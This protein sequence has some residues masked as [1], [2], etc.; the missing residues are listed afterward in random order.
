MTIDRNDPR[1]TAYVLGELEEQE[2]AEFEKEIESA[3]DAEAILAETRDAVTLLHEGFASEQPVYLSA[4]QKRAIEVRGAPSI[5]WLRSR[6]R[7]TAGLA[8]A[9]VVLMGV[10][11]IMTPGLLRSRQGADAKPVA[12]NVEVESAGTSPVTGSPASG[13]DAGDG[14]EPVY[15][16]LERQ[17]QASE[18][19][20]SAPQAAQNIEAVRTIESDS[21]DVPLPSVSRES[22]VESAQAPRQ[23]TAGIEGQVTDLT[24]AA[25]AGVEVAVTSEATGQLRTG[26]TDQSGTYNFQI[27]RA[28]SYRV[29]TSRP[30]FETSTRS[31]VQVE[32]QRNARVD[33]ALQVGRARRS[34]T[35]MGVLSGVLGGA[36]STSSSPAPPLGPPVAMSVVPRF[37]ASGDPIDQAQFNTE[38]YDRI[39]DNPFVAVRE[40]PLATFSI[41]VDTAAYANVRRFLNQRAL[42][43][44]NAV[45]I[46]EMVNYFT[47]GYAGPTDEHPVRVHAEV[48]AAPWNPEHRLVRLGVQGRDVPLE[49]RGPSNLV[50]LIDV[51]GS[52]GGV[53]K[54]PLLRDGMKLLVGQ[55]DEN[56]RVAIVVYADASGMVLPSTPGDQKQRLLRALD[57]LEAGGSTNGAAGIELAYDTATAHFIDGGTNRVILATDGDFNVGVT[58]SGALTLLIEEKAES[59]V[60]LSVLGFGTGNYNDAGL[61]ALADHGN[62]NYAYIDTIRE[63]RKV[64]V[65]QM[66]ST[67]ITIAKD[68][69]IQVEFNPAEVNAYRLI[70]YENRVLEHQDFNDDTKDAGEIGA[71]HT[72]TALFEVVPAGVDM[73]LPGVDPLRYQAP[74]RLS[75]AA[76]RDELVTIKVRY[77][78]PDGEVSRLLEVAVSDRDAP[79]AEASTDYRFAA[80]VAGFGMILRDSPHKGAA[81]FG[82]I[83][84]LAEGSLGMDEEGYR[85]EFVEL[86]RKAGAFSLHA[87]AGNENPAVIQAL[88]TA[89]A[90][91]MA[92]DENAHT[93]LHVAAGNENPAVIQALLTAGADP[94]ARDENAHTPLHVAAGNENPA[95]IQA[96]L[97]AGADPMARDENA[98]TPLHVA[99]GNENPAV[100][101][102]LLTAGAD[103]MARDNN[104]NTPLH[105]AAGNENPAVTQALLTAGADPMARDNNGDTPLHIAARD[106]GNPAV[107]QALLTAGADPTVRREDGETLL[108]G[109]VRD[110]NLAVTQALLTAGA[111]PMAR[112]NNGDTP[113]HIAARDSGNP[114]VIQALLAAGA[115]PTVRRED[116]ETLLH[117][118]VRNENP[119]VTQALLTAGA[120]PMARDN[121]GDTPLHVAARDSGNPAVIQALLTAGADPM[122]QGNNGD[123]PLH[124][125]AGNGN[126]SVIQ[127][128]LAAAGA[129]VDAQSEYGD[130]PLHVAARDSGNPAVIQALLT[131]GAEVDAR[132]DSDWTP[133]HWAAR[134]SGNP[135]VIQALLTAG[136]D[137]MVRGNNGD[138]PLHWAVGNEN[139][140]GVQALLAAGADPTARNEEGDTPLHWAIRFNENLPVIEALLAAGA[141]PTAR[142]VAGGTPG[143]L[144]QETGR[145]R[146][147]DYS[148]SLPPQTY[149]LTEVDIV[150]EEPDFTSRNISVL[151]LKVSDRTND[152]DTALG[153]IDNTRTGVED[154]ITAYR[155]GGVLVYTSKLTG[156]ARRIEITS[157]FGEDLV[158][159]P[160]QAW[161]ED[162]DLD[163]MRELMGP[164]DNVEELPDDDATEYVYDTR[165][166]LFVQYQI[167]NQTVNAI[168]FSEYFD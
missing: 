167:G 120:D 159:D 8:V 124:M 29:Q 69:K 21:A 110:E 76:S 93:P 112:D 37:A 65:E 18:P 56:D 130:T 108:H 154:Y 81:T 102:A 121:N 6:L 150:I 1:W 44:P 48:A 99:A 117:G 16:V 59:G 123:T 116:G 17:A 50:F 33:F 101:Q 40:D 13:L 20:Q 79:L 157:L 38:E 14:T 107:I 155:N 144:P 156:R 146:G 125:A 143:G 88:L 86:V 140:A 28:G 27:L 25:I 131:A 104:G 30:S 34:G 74:N 100:I 47:Y 97:T 98:H 63:A 75:D 145:L 148:Q 83:L 36:L 96:L 113:L 9:A 72:V 71:G 128:L 147:T 43:P 134:D 92:R 53:D 114:A 7:W 77:Q 162:G 161:L 67:L 64:L 139:L 42:P 85:A 2:S 61:E 23:L 164:A 103:P 46:E 106:S 132:T 89:G 129:E 45:R 11:T 126:L 137:P 91:P 12:S 24:G 109:A 141:D 119:A 142:N 41:D 151:G 90:D 26:F 57:R 111:D 152:V 166:I 15:G 80:A 94:M 19:I 68:V 136:A 95:V 4:E 78:E 153:E 163:Q 118:A 168:R 60:F 149:E 52:M 58:D 70:G 35:L 105:V 3:F 55:L 49:E 133:L 135:A 127:A 158:S 115:D 51:S 10:V 5:P 31:G 39:V 62:G 66:A 138:T 160:L 82:S 84:R 54:L 165:G 87:A 22:A 122:V 73:P 32:E